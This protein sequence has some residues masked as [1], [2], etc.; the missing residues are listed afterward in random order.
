M[1]L[2]EDGVQLV[3]KSEKRKQ[4]RETD[5][6]D[7]KA[8]GSTFDLFYFLYVDDGAMMF[9][10]RKDLEEGVTLLYK[11][12]LARFGL[13]MHVGR[14]SK[15]SKTEC[16]FFPAFPGNEEDESNI[17][18]KGEGHV[19][20]T[21]RFKYLGLLITS[22]QNNELDVD[23]RIAQANKAMG[24]LRIRKYFRCKQVGLRAKRLNII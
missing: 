3:P 12:F 9:D 15:N 11:H 8:K 2:Q 14:G 5:K 7:S 6:P 10:N 23:A 16:M 18:I 21:T 22:E 24:T 1:K 17:N 20:F 19:S 4:E 13:E